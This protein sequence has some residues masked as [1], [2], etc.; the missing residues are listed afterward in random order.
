MNARVSVF[1]AARTARLDGKEFFRQA[2]SRL[3]YEKFSSFLANIKEL[4]AHRQ[5]REVYLSTFC[6]LHAAAALNQ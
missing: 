3:S 6:V 4:N 1:I 5:T 2:R